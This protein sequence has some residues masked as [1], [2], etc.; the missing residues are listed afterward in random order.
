[1]YKLFYFFVNWICLP[2]RRE[3]EDV[4]HIVFECKGAVN[5]WRA[6]G[7]ENTIFEAMEHGR[8]SS[9]VLEV[10]LKSPVST[11]TGYDSIKVQETIATAAWYV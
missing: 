4:L 11:V 1:V 7:L 6:L 9:Q 10:L 2:C 8:S 3:D 5:S